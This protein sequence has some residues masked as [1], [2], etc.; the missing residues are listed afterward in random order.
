MLEL[1]T[2]YANIAELDAT[3]MQQCIALA[4]EAEG[5]TAPNPMVGAIVLD[6]YGVV[7]GR[8]YHPAAGKSHAEVFAFEEAGERA[9]GGSLY[10][11][12]EPCCHYGRTPPCLDLVLQSGVS[13][14]VIGMTDPNPQVAGK[15]IEVL[16]SRGIEV[17]SNVC[18]QECR[19]LNRGFIKQMTTGLPWIALKLATTLDGRIADRDGSSR[20]VS[21]PEARMHVHKLRNIFDAVMVGPGTALA[22][23][24]ELTVRQIDGSRNPIR[25][26]F[27]PELTISPEARA[28]RSSAHDTAATT[29]ILCKN[30]LASVNQSRFASHVKLL[31]IGEE[32]SG[33]RNP[34]ALIAALSGLMVHGVN[35][36]LCEGGGN[37]AAS[38][39]SAHLVD[40][41]HWIIAPKMLVDA[42]G[43][44]A[45]NGS[46]PV[47]L[48][49]CI[50]LDTPNVVSLGRDVLITGAV[51]YREP[52][53]VNS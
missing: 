26:I 40:E 47:S 30:E 39:L 8:G 27:D 21:G 22:D 37:F 42:Q 25:I 45:L 2:S 4:R 5:R 29:L 1:G 10:V 9:R 48:I 51:I 44:P 50:E 14:V 31:P 41:V 35:T 36:I 13:R 24:P 3:V 32:A 49:D 15:S 19:W 7:A 17:K 16:R 12:L 20:W 43:K 23:D 38:L 52:L 33:K 18:E 28:C 34:W 46:R 6:Q 53:P 11:S